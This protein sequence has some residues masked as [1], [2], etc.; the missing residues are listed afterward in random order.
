M[1]CIGDHYI[2]GVMHGDTRSL[3]YGSCDFL[4]QFLLN[5]ILVS[6][7]CRAD[8]SQSDS[9]GFSGLDQYRV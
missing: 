7:L 8:P 3:D 2:I 6:L 9:A 5:L 1:N 4:T